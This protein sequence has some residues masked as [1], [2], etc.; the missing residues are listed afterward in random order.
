MIDEDMLSA[1]LHEIAQHAPAPHPHWDSNTAE[2]DSA[3][4][5]FHNPRRLATTHR[6]WGRRAAVLVA[7]LMVLVAALVVRHERSALNVATSR[8]TTP[9][10]PSRSPLPV[11]SVPASNSL[12]FVRGGLG[13]IWVG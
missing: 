2:L 6:R 9:G 10:A 13:R 12:K 11:I 8:G 5:T 1:K 7:V 3:T 4:T